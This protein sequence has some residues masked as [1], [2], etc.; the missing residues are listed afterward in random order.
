MCILFCMSHPGSSTEHSIGGYHC[1]H[2]KCPGTLE[3][4]HKFFLEE[5]EAECSIC[6]AKDGVEVDPDIVPVKYYTPVEDFEIEYVGPMGYRKVEKREK[7][8]QEQ[9]EEV[10]E[11]ENEDWRSVQD[12]SDVDSVTSHW[13]LDVANEEG[14]KSPSPLK[15]T[16]TPFSPNET[17]EKL[18]PNTSKHRELVNEQLAKLPY[19][20]AQPLSRIHPAHLSHHNPQQPAFGITRPPAH[21]FPVGGA[22]VPLWSKHPLNPPHHWQSQINGVPKTDYMGWHPVSDPDSTTTKEEEE[23]TDQVLGDSVSAQGEGE[24][25]VKRRKTRGKKKKGGDSGSIAEEQKELTEQVL[26]SPVSAQGEGEQRVGR[27]KKRGKKKKCPRELVQ[28]DVT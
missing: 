4:H 18:T 14:L 2:L 17:P 22:P 12:F 7:R 27:R 3:A 1:A 20:R 6:L 8:G 11:K 15:G 16:A 10:K 21:A 19:Y 5:D 24:R 28:E 25:R 26:G 13:R 9:E 23:L